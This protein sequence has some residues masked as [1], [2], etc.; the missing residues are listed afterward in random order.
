VKLF[1]SPYFGRVDL[2][3]GHTHA[4]PVNIGIHSFH[5]KLGGEPLIHDWR[6]P[7]SSWFYDSE[8]GD[9]Y[10]HT[11]EGRVDCRLERNRQFKVEKGQLVFMLETSLN[12]TELTQR[13]NRNPNLEPIER[14]GENPEISA[15]SNAALE[16]E[17]I[18]GAV[19]DFL[20]SNHHS[21]GIL[22]KTQEQA[23]ALHEQIRDVTDRIRL[24][25]ARSTVFSGGVVV[26]TAHLAK[27]LEFDRVIVPHC[28]AENYRNVIDRHMLYVACTRAMH[29]LHLTPVGPRTPLLETAV[30]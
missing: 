2:R 21:L 25:N 30:D 1:H 9:A 13:I 10:S 12:I 7:V 22:C 5:E 16:L 19:K 4:Q 20:A 23:D 24:L 11:P 3:N 27:G 17:Q 14:H 8:T 6:A 15:C 28:T 26:A 29:R 18:R